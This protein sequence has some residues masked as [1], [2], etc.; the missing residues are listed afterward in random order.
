MDLNEC[1]KKKFIKKTRIDSE[2]IKSLREMSEI[3]K[4]T[5]NSAKIDKINISAYVSM[6]YDSLREI[7]EAIC[8]SFGYKVTSHLCL[9]EL[10]KTLIN[11]FDFN[12]F[13]RFRFI[14]NRINYYGTKIDFEQ[15]KEIIKKM[16]IMEKKLSEKYLSKF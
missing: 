1:Y 12:E 5:V 4:L 11:N 6:A 7:L 14:R 9:G 2:L 3:K 15:G 13:D 16:F 8:I 10:L